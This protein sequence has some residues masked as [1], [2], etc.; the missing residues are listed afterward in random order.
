MAALPAP[1]SED[2]FK[3]V[4]EV[5]WYYELTEHLS[6]AEKQHVFAVV[7]DRSAVLAFYQ[8]KNSRLLRRKKPLDFVAIMRYL[9]PDW[10]PVEWKT[11]MLPSDFSVVKMIKLVRKDED[12][13]AHPMYCICSQR[14]WHACIWRHDKTGTCIQVGNCCVEKKMANSYQQMIY[15]LKNQERIEAERI[16]KKQLSIR[17]E[18]LRVE[19][20]QRRIEEQIRIE[21]RRIEAVRVEAERT[22][23]E[24]IESERVIRVEAERIETERIRIEKTTTKCVGCG[25]IIPR[26]KGF[27]RCYP[28]HYMFSNPET[29]PKKRLTL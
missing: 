7:G 15:F 18:Q 2:E 24:R 6:E 3:S 11:S 21:Q 29:E 12:A 10:L 19:A 20:E 14:I 26:K 13:T 22:E 9:F 27:P 4:M 17:L 8:R 1:L 28:C 23:V 25:K 5:G 16:K